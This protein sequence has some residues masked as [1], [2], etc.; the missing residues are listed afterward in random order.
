[1]SGAIYK[2]L[3]LAFSSEGISMAVFF[4]KGLHDFGALLVFFT[5][6]FIASFTISA[7]LTMILPKKYRK[8]KIELIILL[9]SIN[10]ALIF[11]GFILSLVMFLVGLKLSTR[12]IKRSIIDDVDITS[13]TDEFPIIK[14]MFGEGVISAMSTGEIDYGADKKIKAL[15]LLS[16][17]KIEGSIG[18][19]KLFLSDSSD[20]TRLYAFALIAEHE[21]ELNTRIQE[22]KKAL[23]ENPDEADEIHT[24][25]ASIYW[26]FLYLG[27]ADE[28]LINFYTTKIRDS[29]AQTSLTA[30]GALLLGKIAILDKDY[31]EA[32]KYLKTA[33]VLGEEKK[34]VLPYLAEV[35][36]ELREFDK[37]QQ[38]MT[39]MSDAHIDLKLKPLYEA[40]KE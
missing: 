32:K 37:I 16:S 26:E 6:H 40:W 12:E 5:F 39:S 17:M 34:A 19:I 38:L 18:K 28:N 36:Y 3:T 15:S 13:F 33:L 9:T 7:S 21:K 20:E 8:F 23:E 22:L 10:F 27:I 4:D 29:V 24:K 2:S 25:L 35:N 31:T 11:I 14:R 30:K 1:M